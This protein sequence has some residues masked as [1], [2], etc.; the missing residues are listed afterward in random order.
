MS[1]RK[2]LLASILAAPDEVAEDPVLLQDCDGG[3]G[4]AHD[5]LSHASE[6]IQEDLQRSLIGEHS[7]LRT[8]V[9]EGESHQ[10]PVPT[11]SGQVSD[12]AAVAGKPMSPQ[13]EGPPT[14]E[15][16]EQHS[17]EVPTADVDGDVSANHD[18]TLDMETLAIPQ[19]ELT[20]IPATRDDVSSVSRYKQPTSAENGTELDDPPLDTERR[21]SGRLSAQTTC[22]SSPQ[23][24]DPALALPE[25]SDVLAASLQDVT[26]SAESQDGAAEGSR[27]E[28]SIPDDD[29]TTEKLPQAQPELTKEPQQV[30]ETHLGEPADPC[31][32]A[33]KEECNVPIPDNPSEDQT[34]SVEIVDAFPDTEDTTIVNRTRSGVRFSDDTT[35][36]KDFLNRAQARKAAKSTEVVL[37]P[38]RVNTPRRS[39]RKILGQLDKNSPSPIKSRDQAYRPRTPQGKTLTALLGCDEVDELCSEPVAHRRS[40]RKCPSAKKEPPGAP[41]FIPVRRPDGA[42]PVVLQKSAAQELAILTRANTRRNKGSS[43]LP[44]VTLETLVSKIVEEM[45]AKEKETRP[46]KS[47][48]WDEKLVYYREKSCSIEGKEDIA[49]AR[50]KVRRLRGPGSLNGTPAPKTVGSKTFSNSTP[51]PKRRGKTKA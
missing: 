29:I 9:A 8:A 48:N 33:A 27:T 14:L 45:P 37:A 49:D 23:R 34:S 36:L 42:D 50:P 15:S 43:K 26:I 5:Q 24:Q 6:V 18:N 44:K 20:L 12:V 51:A 7:E 21:R 35:M 32:E 11:G 2:I 17:P 13:S 25:Q 40:A 3:E 46:A 19:K 47:V 38:E 30:R 31:E 1:K 41:S 22:R 4:T 28:D 16:S 10:A 39:P